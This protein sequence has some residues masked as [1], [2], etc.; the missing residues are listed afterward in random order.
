MKRTV[1]SVVSS[2]RDEHQR[3]IDGTGGAHTS[4]NC[5]LL[6]RFACQPPRWMAQRL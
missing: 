1:G 2:T 6:L 4:D 5:E 3:R